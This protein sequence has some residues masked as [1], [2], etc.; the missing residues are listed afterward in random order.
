M[1]WPPAENAHVHLP[2]NFSAF[3]SV[4]Q[5]IALAS[6]QG[7][8]VLG[9]SNYYDFSVYD[10][11]EKL[12]TRAGIFPLFG[13]EIICFDPEL[14]RAGIRVNDP[15]NPGKIYLCGKGITRFRQLTPGATRL[16]SLIRQRDA[17]RME[18]MTRKMG[19]ALGLSLSTQGIIDKI[20]S[21]LNVPRE[22]VHLQERHV[23][24]AF[25]EALFE[26]EMADGDPV[27][28]QNRLRSEYMKAG[29]AAYVEEKFI[30]VDEA[31]ELIT[32][33]GGYACYPVLADG[34]NPVCEF[35]RSANVLIENL[36]ALGIS[37]AEFIPVRNQCEILTDYVAAMD[38]A[39]FTL[40]AGTE[41]NTREMI[42]L[43]PA[44]LNREP[45]PEQLRGIFWRGAC[46]T[47][48]HQVLG[49]EGKEGFAP[50]RIE[51]LSRIGQDAIRGVQQVN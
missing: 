22:T 45:I 46:V 16:L 2:P 19:E 20:A 17:E 48:G 27:Q 41:H 34:A 37:A 49:F 28:V 35:E 51:A 13:V 3:D 40:S 39:G 15:A 1:E 10:K 43:I 7:L 38:E 24:Q 29:K 4:E 30:S 31:L 8:R 23:A 47:A 26:R 9:A 12:A 25:Q 6:Q 5:L 21:R 44:C 32:E 36:K 50:E 42:P 18:T 14:A 33:L 11:F